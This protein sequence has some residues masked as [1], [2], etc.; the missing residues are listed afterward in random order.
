MMPQENLKSFMEKSMKNNICLIVF[1]TL[2]FGN[3]SSYGKI[4]THITSQKKGQ[5]YYMK[6]CSS[7]HGA[8]NL[9]GNM[10]SQDEWEEL[11]RNNG[12]ELLKLHEGEENTKEIIDY[13]KSKKF[14]KQ[15]KRML[16]FLKEFAY[17]SDYIPTCN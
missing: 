17:D 1:I 8:G 11:F 14:N 5:K 12:L 3:V 6:N 15:S 16:K 2:L 4:K 9:G 13:I 10:N 7:C